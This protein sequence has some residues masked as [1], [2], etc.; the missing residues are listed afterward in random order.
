MDTS[1]KNNSSVLSTFWRSNLQCRLQKNA[2][3]RLCVPRPR[4]KSEE[5]GQIQ[6]LCSR[7]EKTSWPCNYSQLGRIHLT[8][9]SVNTRANTRSCD[10]TT[11][12]LAGSH[13]RSGF[14]YTRSIMDGLLR[15]HT[16]IPLCFSVG[17]LL[18]YNSEGENRSEIDQYLF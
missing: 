3:A 17:F 2:E 14:K 13:S 15:S 1:P 10:G 16:F 5:K 18:I 4:D 11:A 12:Q 6:P 8:S 9:L 7:R